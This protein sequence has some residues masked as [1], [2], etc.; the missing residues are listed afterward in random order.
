MEK[1]T[2]YQNVLGV[3][4]CGARLDLYFSTASKHFSVENSETGLVELLAWCKAHSPDLIVM[5]ATGG[6]ERLAALSLSCA[7][8]S[9][10]VINPRQV[11]DFAKAMGR[12]AK[13]DR[14]D[15]ETL[16]MYGLRMQPALRKLPEA[17]SLLLS[18]LLARRNQLVEMRS[19]ERNRVHRASA[20]LREQ[21]DKH[22]G[23]LDDAIA[24][25]E[26]DIDNQIK[27]SPVY[28]E[29]MQLLEEVKGVGP[30]TIRM[31]VIELPELGQLNGKQIANLV[32]LAPINRDS[33]TQ[34]GKRMIFGGRKNVRGILYNAAFVARRHNDAM[35]V[36]YQRLINAGK[37]P[38]VATIAV[39]RKLLTMLNAMIRDG[40]KWQPKMG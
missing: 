13:T 10:A 40:A 16:A 7:G 6:L 8:W 14:I 28:V 23:W 2:V 31:L 39:A 1:S 24:E 17:A 20:V 38:R 22:I 36:F 34:R 11:R 33:G 35:K 30:Q 25:L 19:A 21:I 27:G 32:G 15:A 4:V 26:D 5:E 29:K 12:L 37:P 3:D 9:V 18:D